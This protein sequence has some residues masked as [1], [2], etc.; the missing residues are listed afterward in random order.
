[1]IKSKITKKPCAKSILLD[2]KD[3]DRL[4]FTYRGQNCD[5]L[6]GD[7]NEKDI[8]AKNYF[9][10]GLSGESFKTMLSLAKNL[11]QNEQYSKICLAL[12]S[13][14]IRKEKNLKTLLRNI[15]IV[16]LNFEEAQMLTGKNKIN[17]CLKEIKKLVKELVVIT[18][19]S[20]GAYAYDGNEEYYINSLKITKI[21]DTT[22][23][24]DSFAGT[25]FYFYTKGYGIEKSL[26]YAV[27]NSG[28]VIRY[29]GPQYGLMYYEDLI[30]NK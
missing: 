18:D 4:I 30:K 7:F 17:D 23:A 1:M 12:S 8:N 6:E 16:V 20:N 24:G 28:N 9:L 14:L 15:D 13:H 10:S 27:K 29:K 26:Q 22:G 21:V 2:T 5:L 3:D 11:K 19:A 25:L